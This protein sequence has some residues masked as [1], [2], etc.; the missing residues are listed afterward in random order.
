MHSNEI[1]E[2]GFATTGESDVTH[3]MLS[4]NRPKDSK[5]SDSKGSGP[6]GQTIAETIHKGTRYVQFHA[7]QNA[8][9]LQ[10]SV[11]C[12]PLK[13]TPEISDK[14]LV[15]VA[16]LHR[17]GTSV[18]HRLLRALD[19][20]TGFANTGHSEDEG[21]FLQSIVPVGMTFGGPG[22][23]AFHP[24]SHL[25]EHSEQAT[26]KSRDTLLREWGAHWDMNQHVLLEKSPPTI[27][28]TRFFQSLFPQAA[29]ICVVRHPIPVSMATQKWSE[30]SLT[31]LLLHWHVAHQRFLNDLP[32]LHNVLVFRYEDFIGTP[33]DVLSNIGSFLNLQFGPLGESIIDRNQAYF[34]R[35]ESYQHN[36]FSILDLMLNQPGSPMRALGYSLNGPYVGVPDSASVLA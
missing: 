35:W 6:T 13:A 19:G 18:I 22:K 24:E 28:R 31:E 3:S 23:F 34:D 27:V 20:I 30:T 5:A 8:M 36:D 14:K 32:Y 17:S 26:D 33:M 15:F 29:F 1:D 9:R 7:M 10:N 12:R 16:G 4:G 21:Q 2:T 11:T 25:T